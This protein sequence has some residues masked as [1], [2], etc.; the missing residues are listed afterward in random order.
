MIRQSPALAPF[1]QFVKIWHRYIDDI[2]LIWEGPQEDLVL[3][4]EQ[5]NQNEF[6]LRFTMSWNDSSID[7]DITIHKDDLGILSSSLY[8]K[9]TAGN[10]ILHASSFHPT[11]LISSIPYSQYL[12]IK[13]N[14]TDEI[15]FK[16][17]ADLL[18]DRLLNRGYSHRVLK[19][20]Y[21]RATN[22]T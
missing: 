12:R 4:L 19:R 9:R 5:L 17:E 11:N 16:Q 3:F 15:K 7:F 21:N 6:N 1:M 18:R 14:C 20:A 8:R 10:T 2:F 13:R 22:K